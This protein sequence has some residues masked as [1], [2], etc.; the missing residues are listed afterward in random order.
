MLP[1][2][3]RRC[4]WSLAVGAVVAGLIAGYFHFQAFKANRRL[5]VLVAECEDWVLT[6]PA[7]GKASANS[8]KHAAPKTLTD[9]DMAAAGHSVEDLFSNSHLVCDP[10]V[11]LELSDLTASMFPDQAKIVDAAK[12]ADNDRADGRS[13]AS[14]AFLIFCLPL[15]WYLVLDRIRELSAAIAGRDRSR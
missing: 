12:E 13:S 4:G 5:H 6:P 14:I 9:A 7:A 2:E 1:K 10:K 3:K 11:L 8:E 15:V